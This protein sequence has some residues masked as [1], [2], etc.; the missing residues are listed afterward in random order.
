ML[1]S[2]VEV[3][4][5]WNDLRSN[6]PQKVNVTTLTYFHT[7]QLE[8]ETPADDANGLAALVRHAMQPTFL[9]PATHQ[10][11][12]ACP[13]LSVVQEYVSTDV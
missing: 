5:K 1:P 4:V 9:I 6:E 2:F 13:V 8:R 10:E 3:V 11:H 7:G 12:R